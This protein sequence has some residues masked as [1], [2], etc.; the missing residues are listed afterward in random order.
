MVGRTLDPR[1]HHE[2]AV[3]WAHQHLGL[4]SFSKFTHF[5]EPDLV[6]RYRTLTLFTL[7]VTFDADVRKI[8]RHAEF[9]KMALLP[10]ET[11]YRVLRDRVQ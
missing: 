5:K 8:R 9:M 10:F 1:P 2:Q 4:S 11:Q 3:E 7:G 6:V